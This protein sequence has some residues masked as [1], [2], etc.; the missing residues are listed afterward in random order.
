[1]CPEKCPAN[2]QEENDVKYDENFYL[3][4]LFWAQF[5]KE[6]GFHARS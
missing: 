3:L 1:M 6:Q 5:D 2:V 4:S